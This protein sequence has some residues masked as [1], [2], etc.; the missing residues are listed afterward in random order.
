LYIECK[1]DTMWWKDLL[2]G[3]W[4]GL[5]AWVVLVVHAFGGWRE[6]PVFD[7]ARATNWYTAG[8]LLGVG[9]VLGRTRG[10]KRK[11]AGTEQQG[12][13]PIERRKAS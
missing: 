6:Y 11:A 12:S 5:T 13:P 2:L 8:F 10:G 3:F 4:N 1:E 9:S 7:T